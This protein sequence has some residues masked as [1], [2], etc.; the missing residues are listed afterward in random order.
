MEITEAYKFFKKTLISLLRLYQP[1]KNNLWDKLQ[2]DL[3]VNF[4]KEKM[5]EQITKKQL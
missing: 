1:L 4:T 5:I 3:S 2:S